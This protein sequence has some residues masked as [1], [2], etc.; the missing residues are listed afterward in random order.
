MAN[1][2]PVA[3]PADTKGKVSAADGK[4]LDDVTSYRSLAGA[5]QYLTITRSDIAYAMQQ[6]CL[7]MHAPRDVHQTMLK[8]ILRYVK[9]T[10]HLG[11]QPP[12]RSPPIRMPTGPAVRTQDALHRVSASSSVPLSSHG[13]PNS[14]PQ[15]RDRAPRRSTTP[16][17]TPFPSALGSGNSSVSYCTRFH[18]RRLHSATTYPRYTCLRI[19]F[20][21]GEPNTSSSTYI[22]SGRR[23]PLARSAS[24][25]FPVHGS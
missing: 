2:K 6:V 14:K 18:R 19:Q 22:L 10:V 13:R 23:L 16:L 12:R 7:H 9:G 24:L 25:M 20:I 4:P 5:L 15:F 8:R 21:T 1:C 11:V 3:T 17:P